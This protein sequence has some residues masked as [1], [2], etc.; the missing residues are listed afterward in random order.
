MDRLGRRGIA[1]NAVY[2]SIIIILSFAGLHFLRQ[3]QWKF[4]S[5]RF[6]GEHPA[7]ST[8]SVKQP[9]SWADWLSLKIDKEAVGKDG[10]TFLWFQFRLIQVEVLRMA[11]GILLIVMHLN[12]D[13]L[14]QERSIRSLASHAVNSSSSVC[15][16]KWLMISGLGENTTSD[17]LFDYLKS[18]L[19]DLK[20]IAGR[21]GIV[22]AFD[23]SKLLPVVD[24]LNGIRNI[25][26]GICPSRRQFNVQGG[27]FGTVAVE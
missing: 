2:W 19:F 1:F 26:S 25:S 11:L 20:G 7:V 16:R 15:N 5:E 12:G 4:L 24:Q 21:N 23:L 3:F 8:L 10:A 13:K 9:T 6:V 22:L 27:N 18:Q 17:S 14:G